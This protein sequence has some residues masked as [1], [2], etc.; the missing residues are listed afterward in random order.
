M[1]RSGYNSEERCGLFL[2][3]FCGCVFLYLRGYGAGL[4]ELRG[5]V[6]LGLG[7]VLWRRDAG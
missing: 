1:T 4:L 7:E 6:G 5:L 3:F 2:R